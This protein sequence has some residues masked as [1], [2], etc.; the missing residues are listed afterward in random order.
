MRFL[1]L[2]VV[3]VL[4]LLAISQGNAAEPIVAFDITGNHRVETP[5]ILSYIDIR[6]GEVVNEGKIE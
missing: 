5:T 1:N 6:P 4:S 2:S 3:S